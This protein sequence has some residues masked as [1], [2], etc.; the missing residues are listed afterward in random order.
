MTCFS[1]FAYHMLGKCQSEQ[2]KAKQREYDAGIIH[3]WKCKMLM[4][5]VPKLIMR[6]P[7]ST[8]KE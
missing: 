4:I 7:N 3:D 6:I 5:K 8:N 1:S 2:H